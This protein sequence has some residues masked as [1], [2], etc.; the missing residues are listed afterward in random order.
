MSTNLFSTNIK[1]LGYFISQKM[2]RS[3][4]PS[5]VIVKKTFAK[6]SKTKYQKSSHPDGTF[7]ICSAIYMCV[8][9]IL[10]INLLDAK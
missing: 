9:T 10:V 4:K 5:M 2:G 8:F 3:R 7:C 1:R 6:I